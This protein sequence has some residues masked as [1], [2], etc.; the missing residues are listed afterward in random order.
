MRPHLDDD[1]SI[2]D[3]ARLVTEM[4]AGSRQA[5]GT[6][7]ARYDGIIA[8]CIGRA[9]PRLGREDVREINATLLVQLCANDMGKLRGFDP[10]R[11]VK[12]GT[13]VGMLAG[14]C[15]I[16]HMRS[17]RREPRRAPLD[18]ADEVLAEV[19][20]PYDLLDRK[21]RLATACAVIGE[22]SDKDQEF[23]ALYFDEE[24]DVEQIAARMQVSVKTVYTKKHKIQ[25]RIE[26]RLAEPTAEGDRLAA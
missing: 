20:T 12:L 8:R 17:R 25:S 15:A 3:Q 22:L 11:G 23:F 24:L 4:L 21:E 5:W 13:W 18:E 14:H 10:A 9:A 19:P 26:A 1:G 6:F 7:H 16:D 2:Q